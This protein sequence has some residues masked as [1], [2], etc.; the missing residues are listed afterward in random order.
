[1]SPVLDSLP[2]IPVPFDHI[3]L[4][5]LLVALAVA[6]VAPS[7]RPFLLGALVLALSV[8][9]W[10]QSRWQPWLYQYLLMLSAFLPGAS[11]AKEG[12]R[13]LD[14]CRLVLVALY[15]WSGLQK[16]NVTFV[17]TV[18]PWLV[19]P[20]TRLLPTP[21][22]EWLAG[23]GLAVPLLETTI[24]LALLL[25]RWRP[26]AVVLAVALHASV[27]L[28][29]GPL[30]HAVNPVIWPW[31]VAMGLLVVLLF[32]GVPA[33]ARQ[34]LRPARRGWQAVV[35]VLVLVM[36]LLSVVDLWDA[37][38]SG[39]LYSGNIREAVIVVT[40]AVKA[41]LPAEARRHVVTNRTGAELLVVADWSMA[42]VG[43]PPYPEA[44]VYRAVARS[45]CGLAGAPADVALVT[46]GKPGPWTGTRVTTREDCGVLASR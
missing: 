30:G 7:P 16:L 4:G 3:L 43:A 1:M 2:P 10:D 29:L 6:A 5:A 32:W 12:D 19:E 33:T 27:L 28:L 38:L 23:A 21:L 14:T 42:E 9:I 34:I 46:F 17:T 22:R 35:A 26:A 39:A 44:R 11:R 15:L 45:V 36:P 31:N 13:A 25:P 8:A 20:L 24:A 40:S 41:R 18:F 37:Y